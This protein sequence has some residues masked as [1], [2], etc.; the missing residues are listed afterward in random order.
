MVKRRWSPKFLAQDTTLA[1][2]ST[3]MKN[4]V[5]IT[6]IG[7]PAGRSAV[8]FFR[9]KG[10]QVV[11]TDMREVEGAERFHAVPPATDPSFVSSL[12]D[13]LE[14]ERPTLLVPTVTE[15]LVIVAGLAEEIRSRGIAV[16]ISS[17]EATKTAA[18]KLLTARF[19]GSRGLAVPLTLECGASKGRIVEEIG[20]PLLAKPDFSRGGRGIRV[21]RNHAELEDEKRDGIIFQ[22]FVPGR[23]FDGNLFIDEAREILASVVLEK[24]ELKEGLT[25]N[26]KAV[27]RVENQEVRTLCEDAALAMGLTGP[28]DI[29]VRLRRDG[30]PVV[31]EINARLGGNVL[32]APEVLEALYACWKKK[33]EML[34]A[35]T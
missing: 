33:E 35:C 31:L 12:M 28:V 1:E 15:E 20:F 7:G 11:G 9:A 16:F 13:I 30:T 14:S 6:G 27:E 2:S 29:D 3:E 18:S 24:T 34:D 10:S 32:S 5:L 22:E 4:R 26:A 17:V 25:G 8:S 23:E 19:L 21:I